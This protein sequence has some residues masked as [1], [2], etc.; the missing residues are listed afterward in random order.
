MR[1]IP[2]LLFYNLHV[3]QQHGYKVMLLLMFLLAPYHLHAWLPVVQ[4]HEEAWKVTSS[5]LL[6]S[7]LLR[8]SLLRSS[9]WT[10][11]KVG[12]FSSHHVLGLK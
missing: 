2:A 5:R 8:V 12:T 6:C 11:Q 3:P 4:L 10:R 9:S 7:L 1:S